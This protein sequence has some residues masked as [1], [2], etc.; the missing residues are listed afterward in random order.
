MTLQCPK[1]GSPETRQS[2]SRR[3]WEA[4]YKQI[5]ATSPYR[6][7]KC[8]WRIWAPVPVGESVQENAPS[9][10]NVS[11]AIFAA[12]PPRRADLDF[13]ALDLPRR[14]SYERH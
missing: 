2:R 7:A 11:D 6:C 3:A 1:C 5:T 8:G 4:L 14:S 9:K 13:E 12:A 10:P